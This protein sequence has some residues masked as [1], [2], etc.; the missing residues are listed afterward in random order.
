MASDGERARVAH[1][2]QLDTRR[3]REAAVDADT[4]HVHPASGANDAC[5]HAVEERGGAQVEEQE[6]AVIHA[7]YVP[8]V[9][10]RAARTHKVQRQILLNTACRIRQWP[11]RRQ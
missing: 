3:A 8:A 7:A 4:V 11:W 1:E 9:G 6:A 2:P 10:V 5:E